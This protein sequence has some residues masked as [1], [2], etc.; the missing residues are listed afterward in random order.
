[1]PTETLRYLRFFFQRRLKWEPHVSIM[2]NQ[3]QASVKALTVLGNT[4][5]G[6][7]MANWRLILNVVCLLVLTYSCQLWYRQDSKGVHKLINILQGIQNKMAKVVTGAFRTAPREA[8][9]ELTR[10]LPM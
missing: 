9:L 1:M 2:S 8:L 6:L 5:Q 7:S 4:I 3:A 10:M